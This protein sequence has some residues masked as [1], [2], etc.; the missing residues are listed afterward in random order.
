M[1]FVSHILINISSILRQFSPTFFFF[2]LFKVLNSIVLKLRLLPATCDPP[3]SK[4]RDKVAA[5]F[6]RTSIREKPLKLVSFQ[7]FR[8]R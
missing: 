3:P 7:G 6:V 1:V 8:A 4:E 2:L 5:V